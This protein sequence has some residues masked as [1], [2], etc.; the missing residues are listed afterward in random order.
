MAFAAILFERA[1]GPPPPPPP[2]LELRVEGGPSYQPD[3]LL[4]LS[5]EQLRTVPLRANLFQWAYHHGGVDAESTY[6]TIHA[7]GTSEI[8][9]VLD[10]IDIDIQRTQRPLRGIHV[11]HLGGP[12]DRFSQPLTQEL[13]RPRQAKLDLDSTATFVPLRLEVSSIEREIIN[14]EVHTNE[15]NC[16]WTAEM[17]YHVGNEERVSPIELVDFS[18][19]TTATKSAQWRCPWFH[20]KLRRRVIEQPQIL[21]ARCAKSS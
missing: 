5:R 12:I 17:L 10:G 9:I 2:D 20:G 19:R 15:C 4:P 1:I 18:F 11:F 3:L 16:S 6:L 7:T 14:L 8:P 21:Q 13:V